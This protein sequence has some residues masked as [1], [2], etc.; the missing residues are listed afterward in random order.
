MNSTK[1]LDWIMIAALVMFIAMRV[2]VLFLFHSTADYSGE[3]IESV[4]EV[5]EANPVFKATM[6]L[7][8]INYMLQF[9]I[10]PAIGFAIYYTFR[11]RV[12]EGKTEFQI[13]QYNVMFTFFLILFNFINDV[14]ALV[15]FIFK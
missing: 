13:L 12:K 14:I 15:G 10:L 8:M 7:R 6:G 2:S 9:I 4:T 1:E 5:F 11:K 3:A